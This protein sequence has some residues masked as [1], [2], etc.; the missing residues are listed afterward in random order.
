MI[1]PLRILPLL[2]AAL[3]F[4]GCDRTD[5]LAV[6]PELEDET[7][8]EQGFDGWVVGAPIG[9]TGTGAIATGDASA[10][11]SYVRLELAQGSDVVWLQRVFTLEANTS[12][13]VTL[14]ADLRTFSGAGDVR[15]WAGSGTPT[16]TGFVSQGPVPAQWT[17]TLAPRP[18]TTDAQGRAWVALAVAGTGQSGVFGVDLLGAVF[19]RTGS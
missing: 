1:R 8:F 11:S 12:Y 16:G 4:A 5:T 3:A 7:S 15:A 19:V 14:S 6:D 10:G 13:N 2:V 9:S 17:R 18:V